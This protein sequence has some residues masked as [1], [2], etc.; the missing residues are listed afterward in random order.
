MQTHNKDSKAAVTVK[1]SHRLTSCYV[2]ARSG[3]QKK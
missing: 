1:P 2:D 3:A